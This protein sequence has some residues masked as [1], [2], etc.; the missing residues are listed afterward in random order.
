MLCFYRNKLYYFVCGWVVGLGGGGGGHTLT[1]SIALGMQSEG[2]ALKMEKQQL[3]S[4]S[5]QC[6]STPVSFGQ[7]FLSKEQCDSP[8]AS[9]T[10]SW[11]GSSWF[12][13]VPLN[14]KSMKWWC[15]CDTTHIIKNAMEELK[16]LSQNGFQECFQ[17]LYS[18]SQK[19]ILA[20]GDYLKGHAA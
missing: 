11:P 2:N 1:S 9:P 4:L 10:L 8:G 5:W 14:E 20:L 17:H 18:C 13:P 12:L 16:R 15:C 7:G 3:V 19:Y 6:S